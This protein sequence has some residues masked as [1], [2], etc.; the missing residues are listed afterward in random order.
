MRP[1]S[2]IAV[3]AGSVAAPRRPVCEHRSAWGDIRRNRRPESR[4]EEGR[5]GKK[6]R[7]RGAPHHYKKK[8]VP[9]THYDS[10]VLVD[11]YATTAVSWIL[12]A[13]CYGEHWSLAFSS[14]FAHRF[15]S[16]LF[17]FQAEDGIRDK[18]M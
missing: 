13:L 12:H 16:T 11:W 18:G 2:F 6:W 14:I 9:M 15:L 3:Q 7:S 8:Q 4:S 10:A 17:F 5:V 1:G